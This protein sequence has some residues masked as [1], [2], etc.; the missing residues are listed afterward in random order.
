MKK[1][2][3]ISANG[4]FI[5]YLKLSENKFLKNLCEAHHQ[6]TIKIVEITKPK[7]KVFIG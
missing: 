5:Q 6:V 7:Y 2:F 1:V 3:E 4:K